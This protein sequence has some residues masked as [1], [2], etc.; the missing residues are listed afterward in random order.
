M[1]IQLGVELFR[2]V[3]KLVPT[4]PREEYPMSANEGSINWSQAGRAVTQYRIKQGHDA[5]SSAGKRNGDA[6]RLGK[7]VQLLKRVGSCQ[8]S[9]MVVKSPCRGRLL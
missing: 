5:F 4:L 8:D 2:N 3:F 9:K 7:I 1:I 6:K